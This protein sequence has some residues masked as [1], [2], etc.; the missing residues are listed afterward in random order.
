MDKNPPANAE[1]TVSVPGP[2][3]F[4]VLQGNSTHAPWLLIQR[5]RVREPQLLSPL[6]RAHAPKQEKLPQWEVRASHLEEP[7]LAAARETLPQ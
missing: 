2:G 1:D 5:S 3:R 4:H 6:P 7:H